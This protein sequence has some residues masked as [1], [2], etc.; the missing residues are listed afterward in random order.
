MLLFSTPSVSTAQEKINT[1][2]NSPVKINPLLLLA[3]KKQDIPNPL[4]AERVKPSKNEL[5]YWPYFYLTAQQIQYRN[6]NLNQSVAAQIANDII[7][8]YVTNLLYGKKM[9]VAVIPR[10]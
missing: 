4:L 8:N 6:N 10:F 2:K 1:G 5:M 9:P 3:F 7:S